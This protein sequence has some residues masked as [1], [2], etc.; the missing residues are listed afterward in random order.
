MVRDTEREAIDARRI[1]DA[2]R[3]ASNLEGIMAR[4]AHS[5]EKAGRNPEDVKLVAVSKTVGL[6]EIAA[7]IQAGIQWFGENRSSAFKERQA[8][9]PHAGWHYIGSIQTNKIK[10][11]VGNAA[12]VHSVASERA[13]IAIDRRAKALGLIQNVLI[14]V[15]VSGEESKDGI[16]RAGLPGL[17]EGALGCESI[18][19]DGLMTIA[20]IGDER[21]VR[22]CFAGLRETLFEMRH[23]FG[24]KPELPLTELS[25]GMSDDF[26]IAVEE[27]ATIV[28]IG[29]AVWL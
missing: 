25:M 22:Q 9:F 5:A 2:K 10:D 14:E 19:V 17:L 28:R 16:S 21:T 29:R 1:I 4:I 26:G 18:I 6:Q 23:E 13:L 7:A 27:G 15:N 8:A 3:I 24:D 12:L 11:Y 20:P